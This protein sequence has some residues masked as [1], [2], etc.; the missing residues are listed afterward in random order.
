MSTESNTTSDRRKGMWDYSRVSQLTSHIV[1]HK[2]GHPHHTH[3]IAIRPTTVSVRP[4]VLP[5]CQCNSHP[6]VGTA[7]EYAKAIYDF[8]KLNSG[9]GYNFENLAEFL[10]PR[11]SSQVQAAS[12]SQNGFVTIYELS[13]QPSTGMWLQS[14]RIPLFCDDLCH[15]NPYGNPGTKKNLYFLKG[16]PSPE[17]IRCIGSKYNLD[18]EFFRRYIDFGPPVRSAGRTPALSLRSSSPKMFTLNISTIQQLDSSSRRHTSSE[19]QRRAND[20]G[21]EQYIMSLLRGEAA[22]GD[23]V[24]RDI[25]TIDATNFVL[26]QRI[27][28]YLK[29]NEEHEN[30]WT[31][32]CSISSR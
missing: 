26:E 21:M 15:G 23:P 8:S 22:T 20:A 11:Y 31:C 30:D 32:E 19:R 2:Q 4:C 25:W 10:A 6:S 1:N 14:T 17:W 29:E 12:T 28:I 9:R 5:P 3:P 16:Y 24:V 13:L 7:H 18:P 27:F